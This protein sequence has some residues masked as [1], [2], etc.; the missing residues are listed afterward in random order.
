M[1]IMRKISIGSMKFLCISAIALLVYVGTLQ[2]TILNRTAVK[3]WLDTGGVYENHLIPELIRTGSV[4]SETQN[5]A[6]AQTFSVPQDALKQALERTFTPQYVK[7]QTETSLDKFY[8]WIEGKSPN[9][10]LSIPIQEKRDVF[11]SELAIASESYVAALP[12]CATAFPTTLC[13][14]AT[15]SPLDY[16]KELISQNI[17]KSGFFNKPITNSEFSDQTSPLPSPVIRIV[18]YLTE[19]IIG[20]FIITVISIAAFL[21]L[22]L[23]NRRLAALQSL[24]KRIFVSQLFT[25]AA[26]LLFALLFYFDILRFS[27]IIP[28]ATDVIAKTIGS[29]VKIAFMAMALQLALLSGIVVGISLLTWIGVRIWLRRSQSQ[30][31]QPPTYNRQ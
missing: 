23:P 26:A 13:R 8:D 29:S 7:S 27:N 5:T 1:H 30:V 4:P 16:T 19:I 15:L 31:E 22:S 6:D 9:F 21:W 2:M 10:A 12:L 28:V 17:S 3:E 20:L 24:A 18:P 11:I 25:F 14:P